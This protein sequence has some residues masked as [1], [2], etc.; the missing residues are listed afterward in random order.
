MAIPLLM[1]LFLGLIVLSLWWTSSRSREILDGWVAENG[2]TLLDAERRWF[3]RGPFFFFAGKG[4]EVFRVE[5]RDAEGSTRRGYVRVGGWWLGLLSD[6][7]AV[8]WDD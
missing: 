4:H 8:E 2:Y 6:K 3:L 1:V 7:V 5:V